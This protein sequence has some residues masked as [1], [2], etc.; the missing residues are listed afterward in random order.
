M[1]GNPHPG[2]YDEP[3]SFDGPAQAPAVQGAAA[4]LQ[5]RRRPRNHRVDED[6]DSQ[7][8][9]LLRLMDA[10]QQQ[11]L[12]ANF[13][14]AMH[15]IPQFI[16]ARQLGHFDKADP[17]WGKGVRGALVKLDKQAQGKTAREL[18]VAAAAY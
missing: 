3:N 13:A 9:A 11:R 8:A 4:E 14:E 6:Y 16:I 2:A 1:Q 7:P 10:G 17:K 12:C 18:N 5:R 15:G